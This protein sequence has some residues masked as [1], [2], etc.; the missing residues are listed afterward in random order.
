MES[1][2]LNYGNPSVVGKQHLTRTFFCITGTPF[3]L[4]PH[5]PVAGVVG[6]SW[7]VTVGSK[8]FTLPLGIT[9]ENMERTSLRHLP[10]WHCPPSSSS[11]SGVVWMPCWAIS[12]SSFL[13]SLQPSQ[14]PSITLY[15]SRT[16]LQITLTS[17]RPRTTTAGASALGC[18]FSPIPLHYSFWYSI[19]VDDSSNFLDSQFL[20]PLILPSNLFSHL[21][22]VILMTCH[23]Q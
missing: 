11:R 15:C 16:S 13:F 14:S 10:L 18:S 17:P 21:S 2:S 9:L 12:V 19:Y 23:F 4:R 5:V 3:L 6:G 8:H 7:G 20:E 1:P 22:W